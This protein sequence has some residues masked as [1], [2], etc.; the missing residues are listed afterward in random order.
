MFGIES[1][2]KK[3][4][5]NE[6]GSFH[7]PNGC[8]R[9]FVGETEAQKQKRRADRAEREARLERDRAEKARKQR[10]A[11]RKSHKRMRDRVKNGVC[12]CCKRVFQNL[13]NHMRTKHPEY[14]EGGSLR[15]IRE[16]LGMTQIAL[17]E[18]IGVQSQH[19]SLFENNKNVVVWAKDQIEAWIAEETSTSD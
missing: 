6:N 1:Q 2:H 12:P 3:R 10:D 18:E 16:H 4:L 7:C 17:A 15:H 8:S 9:K 5:I 11:S 13:L 14:G 19:I